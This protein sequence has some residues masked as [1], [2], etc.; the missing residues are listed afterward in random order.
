MV[1]PLFIGGADLVSY[2]MSDV[3]NI[4]P[5]SI[6]TS[7]EEAQS[8]IARTMVSEQGRFAPTRFEFGATI[9]RLGCAAHF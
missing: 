3:V 8:F 2:I 7:P 4:K 9:Y 5:K 6:L 1:H